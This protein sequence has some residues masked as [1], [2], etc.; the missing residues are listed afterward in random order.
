MKTHE[1]KSLLEVREWKLKVS[2]E[3]TRLGMA[4]YH[5]KSKERTDAII[6]SVCSKVLSPAI[7][8]TERR[9]T[10]V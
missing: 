2:S 7:H 10:K 1:P 8:P 6:Q 3:M 9:L 5:E 4:K